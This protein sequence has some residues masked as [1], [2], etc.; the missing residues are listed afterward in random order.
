[1]SNYFEQTDWKAKRLGR[2]TA[3]E[4]HKLMKGGR[5]K[6]QLFG[7]GALTY[8]NEK[9][10]EIITGESKDLDGIK[11]LEWGAANELDAITLFQEQHPRPIEFFGIGN[12]QF[13]AYNAVSGGSPDGLSEDAVIE[14]KCPFNSA[15]HI[16]FLSISKAIDN[17]TE[18][19]SE[20][21]DDYFIQIQFN[22]LCCGKS[23]GY[24]VSYDPRVINHE[25]RLAVLQIDGR[26]DYQADIDYRISEAKKIVQQR[27]K[28]IE[29]GP[30]TFNPLSILQKI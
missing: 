24:L 2:F 4:M 16:D 13:F 11:A 5:K 25:H 22:M 28:L 9:I 29:S 20:N 3:S 17:H 14:I 23:K 15:N 27:L 8:I 1:M 21:W 30:E 6:D 19:L 12:P 26:G 18:W 10:A 7:Q